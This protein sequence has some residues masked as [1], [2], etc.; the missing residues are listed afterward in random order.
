M[1][2]LHQRILSVGWRIS[3]VH[4]LLPRLAHTSATQGLPTS[5]AR[6]TSARARK[7]LPADL[8]DQEQNVVFGQIQTIT[9]NDATRALPPGI[10]YR[11]QNCV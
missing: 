9:Q 5:P 8:T 3:S 4:G 6:V 10:N 7:S 1:A 11:S 2:G